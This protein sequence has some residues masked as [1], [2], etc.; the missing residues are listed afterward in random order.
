M[1]QMFLDTGFKK[2][3]YTFHHRGNDSW[4]SRRG[5]YGH[6]KQY[7][8]PTFFDR[9][10]FH[11]PGITSGG[12]GAK[13]D[14][15]TVDQEGRQVGLTPDRKTR[16]ESL[17]GAGP[18]SQRSRNGGGRPLDSRS[19]RSQQSTQ[20]DVGRQDGSRRSSDRSHARQR[21]RILGQR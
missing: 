10:E 9:R 3:V 13:G 18:A 2:L 8:P 12:S 20:S 7:F 11:D 14:S 6:A 5:V 16:R 4:L 17:S 21:H 1:Q 15:T 19:G